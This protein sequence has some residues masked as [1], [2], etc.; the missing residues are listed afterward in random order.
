MIFFSGLF[1]PCAL[2]PSP[3]LFTQIAYSTIA[4]AAGPVFPS[5]LLLASAPELASPRDSSQGAARLQ[6]ELMQQLQDLS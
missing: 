4:L 5:P 1:Y 2:I 3:K 6:G